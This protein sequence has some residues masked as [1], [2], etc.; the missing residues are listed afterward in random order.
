MCP[1]MVQGLGTAV[2]SNLACRVPKAPSRYMNDIDFIQV[3]Q[4]ALI[5]ELQS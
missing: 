2:I 3:F 4:L 5:M 1:S